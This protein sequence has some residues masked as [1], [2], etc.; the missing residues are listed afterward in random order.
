LAEV[1]V[2]PVQLPPSDQLMLLP[3]AQLSSGTWAVAVAPHPTAKPST[4]VNAIARA[5]RVLSVLIPNC[6]LPFYGPW[7]TLWPQTPKQRGEIED[8]PVR[9]QT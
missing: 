8:V 7:F 1:G 2:L 6:R 5:L 4:R 3:P 9:Y